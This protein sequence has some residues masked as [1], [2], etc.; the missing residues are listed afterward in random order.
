ME[1]RIFELVLE[2]A[3]GRQTKSELAGQGQWEFHP[4]FIG[5]VV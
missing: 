3:S 4:W 5:A 2:T 1:A